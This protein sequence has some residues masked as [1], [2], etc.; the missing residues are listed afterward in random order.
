MAT[1]LYCIYANSTPLVVGGSEKAQNYADLI[2][3]WSQ[4]PLE[5]IVTTYI[6][7]ISTLNNSL[8][9]TPNLYKQYIVQCVDQFDSKKY[10]PF[11]ILA[12]TIFTWCMQATEIFLKDFLC[13]TH[14][15]FLFIH[16]EIKWAS[17]INL[18]FLWY[19][20]NFLFSTKYVSKV[21]C[22]HQV[23]KNWK[24]LVFLLS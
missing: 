16:F 17:R 12:K 6:G 3:G 8:K 10:K 19:S 21:A 2:Y 9:D 11:P 4:E 23:C 13:G 18:N 5:N 24:W 20:M 15:I 1:L 14:Q 7:F 22:I